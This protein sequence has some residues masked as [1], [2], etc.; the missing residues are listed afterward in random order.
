MEKYFEKFIN[1]N[2][3]L[4]LI[5]FKVELISTRNSYGYLVQN[6]RVFEGSYFHRL[7]SGTILVLDILQGIFLTRGAYWGK[8]VEHP[9]VLF[10]IWKTIH[11]S[12]I[13]GLF[14]S[15]TFW[16]KRKHS[17]FQKILRYLQ[18]LHRNL[19]SDNSTD[20]N[21][22]EGLAQKLVM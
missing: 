22:K 17:D 11:H 18:D 8:I 6:Y 19:F 9:C 10:L 3:C 13:L 15:W 1:L 4:S 7:F 21:L 5:P 14:W 20:E 2:Y 16:K 12:L